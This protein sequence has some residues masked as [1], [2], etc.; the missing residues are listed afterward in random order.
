MSVNEKLMAPGTFSVNLNLEQTPN[1][2]VNKIVPWGNIVLTPTRV[3]AEEFTDAQLRDMARY[4]GI[5]TAQEIS[6]EGIEVSGKGILSY[7]GD[8]D[9]RGMVLAR[10][11]GTGA[12]RSFNRDTLDDVIDRSSST[13]YGIL[14][15]E[16]ANQRAVRKGTITEVSFDDTVLLLNYEGSDGDTTTSDGSE[17]TSNQVITFTGTSDISSDQAKFGNTSLNLTTDGF[18][19]VADRPELDLTYQEFTVEWWEYRTSSSGNPTVWARNNDTYAP[20]IF[21]KAVSGRNKAFI[22]HDGQGYGTDEDLNMDMGSIDL[23]QWNHFA[24]SHKGDFF[25]TYKNGVQIAEVKRPELFVRVSS[26]SLQIGKG[27]DG[28]FFEG[29]LDGMVITRGTAKY[30]DAFTPSTS[31]PTATTANKTYTGKHYLESAYRS[32]KT[33]CTA[34]DAEFKMQNDGTIDVGPRS[35]LFTGHEDSTPEGMIVRRLSGSDPNIKGYSG[36]DLSTEFNAE[37][38]VSRVEL[39]ASQVGSTINLGQADAKDVPYKDLFG[40]EL[41]R[42]QI[43][44]END[45][46]DTMRD[47]RAEAYLNEYNKIQKTLN[48]GLEDYDISGDI[49]VGDIIYVYDPDVGF[50]DTATDAALENRDRFEITYQGQILHPIKIRVMGLSFPIS[51]DM[52]V[53]Y[54]DKD[55]NYTDL[56]DYIVFETGITQIEVGATTKTINQDLR[57]TGAIISGGSTNEFTVPDAPTNLA[58]ATGSYQDGSGRPFAFARLTWDEPTNTDG[59]RITDG[60]MYRVRYRQVTDVDGNNLIDSNDNQVTDYEYLTVAFGTQAVVIKGLGPSNTYEFGV[61]AIDNSGFSGGYSILTAVQMPVDATVPPA[62]VAPTGTYGAIASNAA[63]IQISHKLAAAEDADGN[64]IASPTNFTLPRDI[65]HLNVYRSQDSTF[66]PSA[67]TF[68]GEIQARAGHIDGEITAINTFIVSTAGTWYYK[69]T[70]VDVVGNESDPSTA[71]QAEHELITKEYIADAEI[72]TVKIGEAQ[73]TDAKIDTLTASKITAGTISGKEIIIDTD[74]ATDPS[75]PVLGTIRSDNYVQNTDGWII[76]SD[77]SVEFDSGTFR[78]DITGAT[79]TFSGDLNAA[80]GTFSGNLSAAGGTF[81]GTLSGVDG[82]FTGTISATQIS[83]GTMTAD[84][85]DGGE[86]DGSSI[87]LG[88]GTFTVDTSGNMTAT[89]AT[90]T[91]SVT[92]DSGTIGGISINSGDIQANYSAGSTGFLIESDGDAFFNS[93]TVNNPIITLGKDTGSGTPSTAANDRIKIGDA[94]LFN[95]DVSGTSSLVTT[96][97]LL[98]LPDGDEDNPSLAIDG[99]HG[100]LGFFV[101]TPLSGISRMQ[102]TNGDN[103]VASWS[104]ANTDFTVNDKLVLGGSIQ[105][106]GSTGGNS[107]YIGKNSSGTLGF[108]SLPSGNDHPDSDHSFAATGHD[109]DS[110]YYSASAGSVLASSLSSHT[111]H[112]TSLSILSNTSSDDSGGLFVTSVSGLGIRRT[113]RAGTTMYSQ[114]IYPKQTETY[115]LGGSGNKWTIVHSQFGVSTSDERLKEN[116]EDLTLGLDFINSLQPKKYNWTTE[117]ITTDDGEELVKRGDI[118]NI[119]MFGFMAQDILALDTLDDSVNYGIARYVSEQDSYEISHENFIAPLVKAVQELSAKNDELE[120][121][122]AALEG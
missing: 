41:E 71:Q 44:A 70:A 65:D 122:L 81:T 52:G 72:T 68:V 9:S 50:E 111:G 107:Q 33:I 28:N 32:I 79:G 84:I 92:A 21:G 39:T 76:K 30:W 59:S 3:Q 62:P 86:I 93:V 57:A 17:F 45:I 19:T 34:L 69:L 85:L 55:G 10:N 43:L 121:R 90:I 74:S 101:D 26:D 61:Q 47:I 118:A 77:G 106:G 120:S 14:R 16:S 100:T 95:R 51:D 105:V 116:I 110:D 38:Y 117:T 94:V 115:A 48:V 37:D 8:S 91:G 24:I 49:D 96:K 15:D 98:V 99:Q 18:V 13:P 4:V 73:V 12:V 80:G 64:P 113:N 35:A 114:T 104:T 29:Y 108:H 75:N 102:I 42:I 31:A 1:S 112:A 22:T 63:Q 6:E 83:G 60:N 36:V 27:Q 23:N 78:G 87:D 2:I 54:R 20:W 7:L 82:N 119:D 67:S 11:A 89:S 25:R 5:V 109:H 66:T 88:N 40:N 97:S 53:F 103:N 46:P 58:S 56:T